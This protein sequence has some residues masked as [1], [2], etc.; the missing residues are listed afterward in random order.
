MHTKSSKSQSNAAPLVISSERVPSKTII[1]IGTGLAGL[2]CAYEL[3]KKGRNII[4]L[5][6]QN[7]VGGRIQ[8]LRK[9]FSAGFS[10]EAGAYWLNDRHAVAMGYFLELGIGDDLVY[11]PLSE[12]H[13]LYCVRD[14]KVEA[15]LLPSDNWPE[16]LELSDLERR[17]GLGGILASIFAN[18]DLVGNP[19]NRWWPSEEVRNR[20]G[21]MTFLEFLQSRHQIR[22]PNTNEAVPYSSSPGAIEL[23]RPW[24]AWWDSLDKLSALAMIQHGTIGQCLCEE[25]AHLPRWFTT[26]NGMDILPKTFAKR[27]QEHP[28]TRIVLNAKVESI[29]QRESFVTVHY[30]TPSGDNRQV[31]GDYAVCTLP[32]TMLKN[33]NFSPP[34][35]DEKRR[36][37]ETIK[38]ASVARSYIQTKRSFPELPNGAGYTDL[39]I[40]NLL[41]MSFHRAERQGRLLQGFMIGEQAKAFQRM[42]K[43]E[44][45]SFTVSQMAKVFPG[46]TKRTVQHFDY[47]CWDEDPWVGGAYPAFTPEQFLSRSNLS[48][49]EG[50]L[51]FAGEHTSEY[52]G[53]M[54]GALRS[55]QRVAT[56]INQ[57]IWKPTN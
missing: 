20:Y 35:S 10:A 52:T 18:R 8:T 40:G 36:L 24:F 7:R 53:W 15:R 42:N 14:S 32:T 47:K 1:V 26:K 31:S 55:G 51:F 22:R 34:I 12:S 57:E 2:S 19:R 44:K 21:E 23:I 48:H 38:Y 25:Q 43:K 41:D 5:E 56:E 16:S 6:G 3:A 46:L 50:K 37:L 17:M 33:I 54:E 39:P 27:I 30:T 28:E 9:P 13:L 45:E 11:V 29:D 49:R 4:L